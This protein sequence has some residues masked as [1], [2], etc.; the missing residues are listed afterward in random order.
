MFTK[1]NREKGQ[2]LVEYSLILIIAFFFCLCLPLGVVWYGWSDT[3]PESNS[4]LYRWI[5]ANRAFVP[6]PNQEL[7]EWRSIGGIVIAVIYLI[8][9]AA[10]VYVLFTTEQEEGVQKLI[11][12]IFGPIVSGLFI[13]TKIGE[14][15]YFISRW[16]FDIGFIG[17]AITAIFAFL[18]GMQ[19]ATYVANFIVYGFGYNDLELLKFTLIPSMIGAVVFIILSTIILLGSWS[20]KQNERLQEQY[21]LRQEQYKL[22]EER[23]H[24]D[25]R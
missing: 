8:H 7:R 21:R 17:K 1:H 12:A 13:F 19:P 18:G 5:L 10:Y 4:W 6:D 15:G 9:L 25:L 23:E 16:I 24:I 3:S 20:K 11:Q 14:I 22:Q 2:G